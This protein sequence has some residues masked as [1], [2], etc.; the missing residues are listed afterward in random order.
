MGNAIVVASL[1]T[2]FGV[3]EVSRVMI[4]H[5][6]RRP[7]ERGFSMVELMIVIVIILVI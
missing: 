4:V 2:E 1:R 3:L 6:P 5:R 7:G